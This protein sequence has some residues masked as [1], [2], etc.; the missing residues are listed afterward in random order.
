MRILPPLAAAVCLG[1]A[2]AAPATGQQTTDA[3]TAALG[4]ALKPFQ[5][6]FRSLT[7]ERGDTL[8]FVSMIAIETRAPLREVVPFFDPGLAVAGV[9]CRT[10][11]CIRRGSGTTAR[12]TDALHW[13]M[14]REEIDMTTLQFTR[15]GEYDVGGASRV[16]EELR[17]LIP[18]SPAAVAGAPPGTRGSGRTGGAPVRPSD[19][20]TSR[21]APA[22]PAAPLALP[23]S[24][25]TSVP[26]GNAG[27]AA[28][29]AQGA[30]PEGAYRMAWVR[31]VPPAPQPLGG[32]GGT[33]DAMY[34]RVRV[35]CAGRRTQMTAR[36][37]AREGRQVASAP[38]APAW[39]AAAPGSTVAAVVDAVCAPRSRAR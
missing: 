39:E 4:E 27:R 38:G 13:P 33:F 31:L 17:A 16:I 15:D 14:V 34:G 6:M 11:Q 8:V 36:V 30:T 2:L 20:A 23:E 25:W 29:D 1:A 5:R 19:A 26:S 32:S 37:F 21:P 28:V 10:G 3:R 9:R 35:D 24:R 12:Q 18:G 7:L 22:P